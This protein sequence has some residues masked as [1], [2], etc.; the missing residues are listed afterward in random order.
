MK[1][2][3]FLTTLMLFSSVKSPLFAQ[4]DNFVKDYLER[5]EN[6]RKYLILVAENDA[7]A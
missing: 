1:H 5:L 6:S 2:I 7:R 3:L 4:Q